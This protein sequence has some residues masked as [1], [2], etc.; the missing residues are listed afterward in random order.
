MYQNFRGTALERHAWW[1]RAGVSRFFP[2]ENLARLIRE[3][4]HLPRVGGAYPNTFTRT[5]DA[6][7]EIG[8]DYT[9]GLA[10]REYTV[11]TNSLDRLIT[12]HPGRSSHWPN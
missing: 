3:A 12:I 5:V 1:S 7:R 8:T 6:G 11:I 10:T 9:T 2:G 4:E